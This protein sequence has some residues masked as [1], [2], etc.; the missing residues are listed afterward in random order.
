MMEIADYLKATVNYLKAK[1]IS[2]EDIV[3]K[4]V[5]TEDTNGDPLVHK[6]DFSFP[7]PSD[8]ILEQSLAH[9]NEFEEIILALQSTDRI[10]PRDVEDDALEL[11]ADETNTFTGM[12][13]VLTPLQYKAHQQK[14]Q[15]RTK[16][17]ELK[18][19]TWD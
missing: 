16:L 4:F 5:L 19:Q 11:L 15:Y 8:V 6:W 10:M 13:E 3:V 2:D 9:A 1:G 17:K 18:L 14:I 7:V 12:A